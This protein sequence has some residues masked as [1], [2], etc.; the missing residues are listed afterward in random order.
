MYTV[1]I[2]KAHGTLRNETRPTFNGSKISPN[3][4]IRVRRWRRRRLNGE[5]SGP[6]A[7][8]VIQWVYTD[9]YRCLQP[10]VGLIKHKRGRLQRAVRVGCAGLYWNGR[11]RRRR[12]RR[13]Y[14]VSAAIEKYDT[15]KERKAVLVRPFAGRK[16]DS[17]GSTRANLRF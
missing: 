4:S 8:Y 13:D 16:E 14:F 9:V 12:R 17:T 2:A 6:R 11:R 15:G 10:P 7:L 3:A 5:E 1:D